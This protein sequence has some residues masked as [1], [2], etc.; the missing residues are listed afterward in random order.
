MLWHTLHVN[1]ALEIHDEVTEKTY[2]D[3]RSALVEAVQ[4][5]HPPYGEIEGSLKPVYEYMKSFK[6][7][8]DLSYDLIVYWAMLAGNAEYGNW[9]KDCFV[10][11]TFRYEDWATFYE[12]YGADG[13][14]LVFYPHGNLVLA[15]GLKVGDVKLVR[16]V[17]FENLLDRIV[18][19]WRSGN[20]LPLFVSE[21]DSSQKR[22]AILRSGY[23]STVYNAVNHSPSTVER[24]LEVRRG[25][26]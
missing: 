13:A 17:E 19:R 14:T 4:K 26:R 1:E 7:V 12:P 18:S 5:T 23:L 24:F 10:N 6:T 16:K 3:I 9:F 21:G 20:A 8:I 25:D 11:G 2:D 22:N 15:S